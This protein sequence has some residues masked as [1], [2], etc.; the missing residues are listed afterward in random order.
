MVVYALILAAILGTD[1]L[2]KLWAADVL[3][4]QGS[5]TIVKGVFNLTYVENTGVAFS[6]FQGKRVFLIILTIIALIAIAWAF[7]KGFLKGKWG[8]V[9]LVFIFAGALG[10][11][12][13][14]IVRGYVIDLFDF[15][16]IH[17]PVFNVA[18]IFLNVGAIMA[19]IYAVFIDKSFLGDK[20]NGKKD[21]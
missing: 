5:I 4:E 8:R 12:I 14:R 10:N 6:L 17:F 7:F 1:I 11:L 21:D 13:D 15:C 3:A 20:K 18:D 9:T 16:L 19:V 2:V